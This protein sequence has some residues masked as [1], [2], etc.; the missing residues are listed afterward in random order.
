M[1]DKNDNNFMMLVAFNLFLLMVGL[2]LFVLAAVVTT[3]QSAELTGRVVGV[4]D[5]DTITL[6][7]A[8]NQQVKVRLAGIDAP[9]LAQ[10]Y[11]QK[12]KQALSDLAFGK[13]AR[14]ESA[15]LDKYGRTL[16][17]VYVG[18][19]NVNAMLIQKGVAWVYRQY[20]HPPEWERLEEFARNTSAGLW[21]LQPDQR[22]PPWE[23]RHG[24][25]A[26][27]TPAPA[28]SAPAA[29]T[30]GGFSC[31]GKRYCR[32]MTSCEEAKFYLAQCGVGS[33]DGNRD[34]VP[35]EKLCR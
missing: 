26:K 28:S 18:A 8:G 35:C 19:M 14:V 25:A 17:T 12:A 22:M 30:S 10:P 3:A 13:D 7:V 4:H 24:G 11:G 29:T 32:E 34:G 21:A 9:E 15:G 1:K 5:G 33:L 23:W 27:A 16:G 6:L 31:S 2:L 20:P